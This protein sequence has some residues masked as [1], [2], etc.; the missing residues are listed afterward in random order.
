MKLFTLV[1]FAMSASAQE[2]IDQCYDVCDQQHM[3]NLVA[4]NGDADCMLQANDALRQC[5]KD[6]DAANEPPC[7]DHCE[8]Q[9][10]QQL[11]HCKPDDQACIDKAD[12][13]YEHCLNQCTCEG[14]CDNQ[15]ESQ[16]SHCKEGDQACIDRV[17]KHYEEC[18]IHCA[19]QTMPDTT[20]EPATTSTDQETTAVVEETTVAEVSC[21]VCSKIFAADITDC[22]ADTDCLLDAETSFEF[23]FENC[24]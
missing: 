3:E 23:C 17:E 2:E 13:H 14:H 24:I 12:Q 8:H 15:H 5:I 16:L 11:H 21:G 6:C 22:D 20:T 4:C 19:E 10:E 9:H 7:E 18:L 1:A